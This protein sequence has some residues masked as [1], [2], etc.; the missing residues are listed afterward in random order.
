VV[1][2][3]PPEGGPGALGGGPALFALLI[4]VAPRAL[5]PQPPGLALPLVPHAD[6]VAALYKRGEL[7]LYSPLAMSYGSRFSHQLHQDW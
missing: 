6:V 3:Q 5:S 7:A 4:G 2:Y 1:R